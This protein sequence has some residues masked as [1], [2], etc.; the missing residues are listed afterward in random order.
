MS[1]FWYANYVGEEAVKD[2]QNRRTGSYTVTY[3]VPR[4]ARGNV[5]VEHGSVMVERYGN[6]VEYQRTIVVEAIPAG[7]TEDSI[8]WIGVSPVIEDGQNETPHNYKVSSIQRGVTGYSIIAKRVE[9]SEAEATADDTD[10][11]EN[12]G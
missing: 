8:L 9:V 4:K 2:S 7:F 1:A 11:V 12:D 5:S 3:T 10:E 6:L